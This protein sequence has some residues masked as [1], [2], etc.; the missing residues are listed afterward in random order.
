MK[1]LLVAAAMVLAAA[2]PA[3]AQPAAPDAIKI[4]ALYAS[5]GAYAS[6]S[7]TCHKA[8]DLWAEM[9]N[10]QGGVFVKA[11]NRKIPVKLIEYDD[12]SSTAT[13]ATLYNQ[14]ITQDKVDILVADSG[15]VLTSVALPIAREHKMLLLDQTGTAAKFFTPDNPY[16]VL[17]SAP[18]SDTW[19]GTLGEFLHDK[20]QGLG[21]KRVALLYS[22]NDFT[23]AMAQRIRDMAK[24]MP[25]VSLVYDQGTP[26]NTSNYTV[27]VNN[28]AAANPDAVIEFGYPPND[29]AFLRAIEDGG[30]KFNYIFTVYAGNEFE[31]LERNVSKAGMLQTSTFLTAAFMKYPVNYGLDRDQY[32]AAWDKRY[33]NDH[34]EFGVNSIAGYNTGLV[35]EKALASADSMDQMDLRRAIMGLSGNLKTLVGA[36]RLTPEGKQIGILQP[37]GQVREGGEGLHLVPYYPDQYA[38]TK[39]VYPRP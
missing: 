4:G 36:F 19:A 2:L 37:V 39:L 3:R 11:Y 7:F 28:I 9:V 32:R 21:I 22:T 18:S 33:A 27:L 16:I 26:T 5:S 17:T 10:A 8:L 31:L 1:K 15:S 13:A 38:E 35:I 29:I 20:A 14:L 23:G 6:I 34:L 30:A 24:D 12:Q 25:G